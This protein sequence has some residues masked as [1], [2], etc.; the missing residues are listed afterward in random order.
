MA[1]M[2]VWYTFEMEGGWCEVFLMTLMDVSLLELLD[3]Y[4]MVLLRATFIS[5]TPDWLVLYL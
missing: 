5:F 2:V 4:M 1:L 3:P